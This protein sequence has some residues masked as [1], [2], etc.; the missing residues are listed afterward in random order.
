MPISFKRLK[1]NDVMGKIDETVKKGKELAKA[2]SQ[3]NKETISRKLLERGHDIPLV[4]LQI[5]FIG[6][7]G[8]PKMDVVG[9]ADPYFVAQLDGQLTYVSN[10]IGNHLSPVWNAVWRIKN[11]PSTASLAVCVYDK[12][13]GSARDDVIGKFT[14][15]V[16]PGAKEFEIEGPLLALRKGRGTFWLKIDSQPAS[17]PQQRQNLYLFDGPIRYTRHFSPTVGL[18]TASSTVRGLG[19]AAASEHSTSK[20][21]GPVQDPRMYSTWKFHIKGVPLFFRDV[22]QPWNTKYPAAQKIFGPGPASLAVR[23]TVQAGHNMLY[24]RLASNGFGTLDTKVHSKDNT[25]GLNL[26]PE[27]DEPIT[28]KEIL[29]AG[30]DYDERIKPAVYTY[31]ISS[32]DDTLRF[33]ETGAAFFVDF[34]SKHALH[35]NCATEVRYSGEFHPRPVG[36]WARFSEGIKGDDVD[37]ELVVDNNSGTY[38]PDKGMLGAVRDCLEYN[39]GCGLPC[40]TPGRKGFRVVV[41]DR[42]DED[43]V[44]SRE[45]CRDYAVN[46]RGVKQ[47]DLQPH[48]NP[49]EVPLSHG[50]SK[51]PIR[52]DSGYDVDY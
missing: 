38:A 51:S 27:P 25:N 10:V 12:D 24:A 35:A 26:G 42:E 30:S 15:S 48:L 18:F 39:F 37:W 13:E 19:A 4:D 46:V 32:K 29:H 33:S 44:E 31:I 11:V 20:P 49:G 9:S 22:T 23:S 14:S 50:A 28:L 5:Q 45:A 8:L 7:T 52:E 36:G 34:A 1:V 17:D 6:A 40:R 41:N 2:Q 47:E 16:S 3:R 43:L 21:G